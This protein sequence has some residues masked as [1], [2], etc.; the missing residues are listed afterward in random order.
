GGTESNALAILGGTA[1]RPGRVV[2]S[3]AEHPSVREAVDRLAREGNESV[4]VDPEPTGALDPG[5]VLAA[6]GPGTLL[7]TVMTA[8]NE[9]GGVFPVAA[10]GPAVRSA[11]ALFHSDAAQAAGRIAIDVA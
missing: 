10:L 4:A 11:G 5:K 6:A 8:N 1:G 3:G 2:R 7:V 9:Y